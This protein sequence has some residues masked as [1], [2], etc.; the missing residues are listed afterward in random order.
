MKTKSNV[1]FHTVSTNFLFYIDSDY[2]YSLVPFKN[3][4]GLAQSMP[5]KSIWRSYDNF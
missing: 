1:V 5:S 3:Y 2:T 4:D